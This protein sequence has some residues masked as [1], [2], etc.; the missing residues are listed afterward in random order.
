MVFAD[1]D[2]MVDVL[3]GFTPA[4]EWLASLGEEQVVISGFVAAELLQGCENLR[5]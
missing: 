4:L 1:T 5:E 3:R 2:V